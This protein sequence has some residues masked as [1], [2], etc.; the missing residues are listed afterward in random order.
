M[1]GLRAGQPILTHQRAARGYDA[2]VNEQFF[3]LYD[4]EDSFVTGLKTI[5]EYVNNNPLY[6]EE[7]QNKYYASFSFEKGRKELQDILSNLL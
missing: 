6:K 2:L 5:L 3:Q 7:I 4:D 1:D